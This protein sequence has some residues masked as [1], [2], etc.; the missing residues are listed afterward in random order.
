MKIELALLIL[1]SV[2]LSSGSQV[3]LKL[4]MSSPDIQIALAHS[5][6]PLLIATSIMSSVPVLVGLSAFG[7]SAIVWLFVLSK[8]P[9][10]TAYPFVALGIAITVASGSWLFG[11]AITIV[12][13]AG[14]VL[15]ISGVLTIG[16]SS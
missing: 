14:V 15:I 2:L 13:G 12:Q 1:V 4:G 11:E 6:R 7:V 16:M 9:V 5:D 3:L 8:I 10:S